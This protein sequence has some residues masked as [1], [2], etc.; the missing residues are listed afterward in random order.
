MTENPAPSLAEV[1][2]L[3]FKANVTVERVLGILPVVVSLLR[4][5]SSNCFG[6]G[7]DDKEVDNLEHEL[8]LLNTQRLTYMAQV[9]SVL[10]CLSSLDN[11][12]R[13]SNQG[14]TAS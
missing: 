3:L 4:E 7:F 5:N 2:K 14:V 10:D 11:S 12:G 9:E 13:P 6:R 8:F 1:G